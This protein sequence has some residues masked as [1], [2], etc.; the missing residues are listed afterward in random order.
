M[1]EK[2]IRQHDCLKL[3]GMILLVPV[4]GLALES[5]WAA[6][7]ADST[8]DEAPYTYIQGSR[9]RADGINDTRGTIPSSGAPAS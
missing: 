6:D 2:P 4:V 8:V 9:F 1:T 5:G 3:E 7:T